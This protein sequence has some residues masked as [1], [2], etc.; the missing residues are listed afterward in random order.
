MLYFWKK[1][2]NSNQTMFK[3]I[4]LLFLLVGVISACTK[5]D[6]CTKETPTTP[7][8]VIKFK[9]KINPLLSKDVTNLTVTTIVNNDSIAIYTSQTTDS[10]A[11]PLN[12]G[13]NITE[14]LFTQNNT[15]SDPGNTDKVTFAYQR[16]NIYINRACSFK[17]IFKE[18]LTQLEVVEGE[19]WISEI[20]VNKST[21]E[22][23][24]ETHVTI[25]H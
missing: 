17:A 4:V 14:Y 5:D 7:F 2:T 24:D 19:N 23:E 1:E 18:L 22:N 25:F 10:I 11:I 15:T 12:T 6:I 13:A 3:K 21:V 16:D 9:S 8:L 20:E